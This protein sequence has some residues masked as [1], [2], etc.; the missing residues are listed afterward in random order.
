MGRRSEERVER[1]LNMLLMQMVRVEEWGMVGERAR[2]AIHAVRMSLSLRK[3]LG[4]GG[5]EEAESIVER[6][7]EER[8]LDFREAKQ[9]AGRQTVRTSCLGCLTC[10]QSMR[11]AKIRKDMPVRWRS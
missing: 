10:S 3:G 2:W 6:V 1:R 4:G 7:S 5:E 8:V 11:R 9:V